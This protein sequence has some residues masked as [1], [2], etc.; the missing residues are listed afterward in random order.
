MKIVLWIGDGAHHKALAN[1]L[2]AAF[3]LSGII[4]EDKIVKSKFSFAKKL[5]SL[6]KKSF[7]PPFQAHGKNY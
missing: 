1:R 3:S 4:V 2:N 5:K 7:F 6:W